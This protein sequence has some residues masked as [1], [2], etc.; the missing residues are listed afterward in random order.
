MMVT[1][2]ALKYW[3]VPLAADSEHVVFSEVQAA[4]AA[5]GGYLQIPDLYINMANVALA[6]QPCKCL[7]IVDL[8]V[9][10]E[11]ATALRLYKIAQEKLGKNNKQNLCLPRTF[12]FV[13][14]LYWVSF[15]FAS[16]ALVKQSQVRQ[17]LEPL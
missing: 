13:C 6:K 3:F 2:V 9:L 4:V 7:P 5:S 16:E 8:V 11:Y 10:V 15:L 1:L 12:I 17:Q 14:K